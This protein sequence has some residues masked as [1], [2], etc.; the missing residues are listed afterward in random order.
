MTGRS[1]WDLMTSPSLS[2]EQ[3]ILEKRKPAEGTDVGS[4]LEAILVAEACVVGI[5]SRAEK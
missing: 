5:I 3:T 2:G 1:G 4:Q